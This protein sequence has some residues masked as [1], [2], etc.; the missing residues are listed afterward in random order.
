MLSV[1][2]GLPATLGRV[3]G[4]SYRGSKRTLNVFILTRES[5]AGRIVCSRSRE[6]S[7]VREAVTTSKYGALLPN[8]RL[9]VAPTSICLFKDRSLKHTTTALKAT[10]I[11][12]VHSASL[13]LGARRSCLAVGQDLSD[14]LPIVLLL[15]HLLG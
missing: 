10:S 3:M 8:V 5:Q 14:L 6:L 12:K 15:K 7:A 9:N 13:C 2:V 4:S 1:K 11:R